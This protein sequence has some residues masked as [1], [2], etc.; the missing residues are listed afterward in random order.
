MQQKL[1]TT[2]NPKQQQQNTP[3]KHKFVPKLGI[4][5]LKKKRL[6]WPGKVQI[7]PLSNKYTGQAK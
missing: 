1:K 6:L 4:K 3:E 2:T 7:C 5:T